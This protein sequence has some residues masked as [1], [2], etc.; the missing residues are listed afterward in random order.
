M[1][2]SDTTNN[3]YSFL[4]GAAALALTGLIAAP[5]G[6]QMEGVLEEITVTAQKREEALQDVPI[7]VATTSGEKLNAMFSGSDDVLALSG[8]VPGLYAESSNGR[9]AP[10]FYLRGLGN[11]D[12][13]LA[14]SQPV[15]FVMDEVVLEN[16]VLKSF[17][18]F[19][20]NNIEVIR[21]PQGTLFGRNTI[22]GIVKVNTR[23]PDHETSGYV[24]GSWAENNTINLEGA[25]GG[26]LIDGELSARASVL[27]RSRDNWVTNGFT[28]EESLGEYDEA[29]MR[30]Q[31]EWTPTDRFTALLMHQNRSLDGTS[32]IFRANVFT[33]GS[34][35]LNRNYDRET[36]YY[37][38]GDNN[39]QGYDSHGTTLNLTWDLDEV[40]VNSITSYQDADGTSRGDIDGG[41][42]DFSN[43]ITPPSGVD[44]A[45]ISVFGS[46]ATTWP[47]PIFVPSVTED[48]A[49]TSQFTQEFRIA[50][51]TD[52]DFRWQIGAFYF[53]SQL[54]VETEN[55]ASFDD[56]FNL[57]QN[58]IVRQ[59]NRTWAVFGQGSWDVTDRLN[60]T[61]G[62]RYTDDEKEFKVVELAYLWADLAEQG[63]FSVPL[64]LSASDGQASWEG[65][66]NYALTDESSWY[67]RVSSGFRAQTIQGRD[68][69]FGEAASVAKPETITSYEMG[70]KADLAGDRLRL[71]L[72]VFTYEVEDMQL[73]VVGGAANIN[74][75]I[76]AAKG[77]AS[78]FELDFQWLITDNLLLSGGYAFNDTEIVD[79]NLYT[80]ACGSGL[81]TVLDPVNP[82]DSSQYSLD[83]NPFPRAP[84]TTYNIEVRYGAEVG[85]NAEI[86][87]LTDWVWYGE[88]NMPL[89]EAA[90]F[91][92]KD[93]FEG[94]VRV[95]YKN[96]A[97]GWDIAAFGRNV[98][99]EDNVLGYIDFSNNTGF[100]NEP[101]VWGLEV[102]YEFGD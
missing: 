39:P 5:A 48:G 84:E 87:F 86:Y 36:V 92:T 50:S 69:A 54:E 59:D 96:Y 98:T 2:G 64:S 15:S 13:D 41:V 21:G 7:S 56:S 55:F 4:G 31:F 78:G 88:I 76:N 1:C 70:Y 71:N 44:V 72:G 35:D 95:G 6:A 32:S 3:K 65:S 16:V 66:F 82:N 85:S 73:S 29:A 45:N 81:C 19:D 17:P 100:V 68:I 42:V 57:V 22:A 37:D 75:V 43:S 99:D 27:Y 47:G 20:V 90:E 52:E 38:G 58:N 24:K 93:Q 40:T 102:G 25:I 97:S 80:R 91:V 67:G 11:I 51:A 12:F 23:R 74:Q 10:R 18:L 61:A 89:Y 63:F 9:A 101:A 8:R 60:L 79:P 14:A 30:L 77:E 53:D 26:S 33:T 46:P 49:D 94:G 28:G 34:P 83:G 62:V